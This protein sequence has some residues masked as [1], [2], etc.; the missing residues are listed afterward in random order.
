M[1]VQ[2]QRTY[3]VRKGVALKSGPRRKRRGLTF[4]GL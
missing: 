1:P 4:G 3:D 2:V